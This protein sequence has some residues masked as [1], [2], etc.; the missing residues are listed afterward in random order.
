VNDSTYA[1][2]GLGE[3]KLPQG[4]IFLVVVAGQAGSYYQPKIILGGFAA[5]Q[6]S[7]RSLPT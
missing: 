4:F 1:V 2:V 6:T 7:L 5:L 3:A